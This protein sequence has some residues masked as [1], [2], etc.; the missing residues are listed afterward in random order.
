M[1]SAGEQRELQEFV[2]MQKQKVDTQ[3]IIAG[4]TDCESAYT[5]LLRAVCV[6]VCINRL[7]FIWTESVRA[8]AC[9]YGERPGVARSNGQ[10]TQDQARGHTHTWIVLKGK[11]STIA[12][13]PR[14]SCASIMHA[15]TSLAVSWPTPE[16]AVIASGGHEKRAA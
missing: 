16:W 2:M 14:S 7:A 8:R 12:E 15:E 6:R 5:L 4:I 10:R 3:N 1:A 13:L 9:G 11:D